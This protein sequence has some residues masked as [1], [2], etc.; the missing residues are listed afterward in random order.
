[1]ACGVRSAASGGSAC[2]AGLLSEAAW[3]GVSVTP[4]S[5]GLAVVAGAGGEAGLG[6]ECASRGWSLASLQRDEGA[7]TDGAVTR[8]P[9]PPPPQPRQPLRW[10]PNV[11]GSSP[12]PGLCPCSE[13]RPHSFPWAAPSHHAGL[14]SAATSVGPALT[15][16]PESPLL[17]GTVLTPPLPLLS[18][19]HWS[20]LEVTSHAVTC[21]R[22][23]GCKQAKTGPGLSCLPV[24][25]GP[26]PRPSTAPQP[27]PAGERKGALRL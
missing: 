7:L 18:S 8:G 23:L 3:A 17:P 13:R 9:W 24:C 4:A 10:S 1:M 22:P 12:P 19:E 26:G 25:P 27:A 20:R 14:G 5:G 11:P 6:C 16:P 2:Q 15:A 21:W